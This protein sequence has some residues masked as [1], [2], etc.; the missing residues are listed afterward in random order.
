MFNTICNIV[1]FPHTR[2]LILSQ[3]LS[4]QQQWNNTKYLI[5]LW[6]LI[7]LFIRQTY[8][9]MVLHPLKFCMKFHK[10]KYFRSSLYIISCLK[11]ITKI[12]INISIPSSHDIIE[13]TT[14]P[15]FNINF[16]YFIFNTKLFL[17]S[18]LWSKMVISVFFLFILSD[19]S[20]YSTYNLYKHSPKKTCG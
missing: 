7:N 18:Y 10:Q 13:I 4:N 15:I 17:I 2:Y 12:N 19:N 6:I 16:F 9:A 14:R 1:F 20:K 5:Q 3:I 11:N 8:N